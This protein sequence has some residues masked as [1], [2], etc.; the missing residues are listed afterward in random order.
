MCARTEVPTVFE[1]ATSHWLE[2]DIWVLLDRPRSDRETRC[3][4][5]AKSC[6]GWSRQEMETGLTEIR[7]ETKGR[8]NA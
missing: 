7:I 1:G 2:R 8:V 3:P 5:D 4:R 6:L